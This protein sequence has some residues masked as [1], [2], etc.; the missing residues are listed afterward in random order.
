[1]FLYSSTD[2]PHTSS[3]CNGM[4]MALRCTTKDWNAELLSGL[5]AGTIMLQ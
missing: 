1:M 2:L 5:L 4:V 3:F